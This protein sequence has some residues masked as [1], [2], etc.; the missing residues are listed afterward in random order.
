MQDQHSRGSQRNA[1]PSF[2]P[3]ASLQ[4]TAMSQRTEFVCQTRPAPLHLTSRTPP[5]KVDTCRE[6]LRDGA[7]LSKHRRLPHAEACSTRRRHANSGRG[8]DPGGGRPV[9]ANGS[10]VERFATF[11]QPGAPGCCQLRTESDFLLIWKP[12]GG[13]SSL[14]GRRASSAAIGPS[15]KHLGSSSSEPVPNVSRTMFPN[16]MRQ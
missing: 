13:A 10:R 3:L 8:D 11:Q 7:L 16:R 1:G 2:H 15:G 12:G 6:S 14:G 9:R 4:S 5:C